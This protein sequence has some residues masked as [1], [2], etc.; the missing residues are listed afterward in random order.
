MNTNLD[1]IVVGAH[2][3]S[4]AHSLEAPT[5]GVSLS[6]KNFVGPPYNI[7]ATNALQMMQDIGNGSIAP[8]ASIARYLAVSDGFAV[9]TG[10]MGSPAPNFPILIGEAYFISMYTTTPWT[11][12]HY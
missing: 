9:Y 12:S 5:P 2:D 6:G 8:V 11:P 1:Y 3:P 7:V 4:F 10:R